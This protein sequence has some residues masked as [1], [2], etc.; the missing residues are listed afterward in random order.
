MPAWF[1][2]NIPIGAVL[3]AAMVGIPLW[4]VIKRPDT[5][6]EIREAAARRRAAIPLHAEGIAEAV[7]S[8]DAA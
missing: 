3:F 1:W 6:Q 2:L 4:L 5:G 7:R 8:R